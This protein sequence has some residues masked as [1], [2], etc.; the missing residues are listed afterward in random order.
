MAT[1]RVYDS[2]FENR[3]QMFNELT[4]LYLVYLLMCMTDYV[5]DPE[6]RGNVGLLYICINTINLLIH[7]S[8]LLWGSG[9]ASKN[10]IKSWWAKRS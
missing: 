5:G 4:I 6:D 3:L 8:F 7:I 10:K 2:A 1:E 9:K